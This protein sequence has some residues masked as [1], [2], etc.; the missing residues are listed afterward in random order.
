MWPFQEAAP[1]GKPSCRTVFIWFVSY[2][3][4]KE[5]NT[6]VVSWD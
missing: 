3:L 4:G 1:Q 2:P 5:A 6:R